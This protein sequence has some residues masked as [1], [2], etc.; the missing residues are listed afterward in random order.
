MSRFGDTP[1]ID[2]V[3]GG[4]APVLGIVETW[5]IKDAEKLE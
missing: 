5:T 4:Q 2:Q 1:T 3:S